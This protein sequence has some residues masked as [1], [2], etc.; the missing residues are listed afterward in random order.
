[1]FIIKVYILVCLM[2][3]VNHCLCI[4]L[5]ST[6]QSKCEEKTTALWTND[7]SLRLLPHMHDIVQYIT[8]THLHSYS[9]YRMHDSFIVQYI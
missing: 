3:C 4:L 1:M 6:A 5:Y 2:N 9:K 8:C 7:E